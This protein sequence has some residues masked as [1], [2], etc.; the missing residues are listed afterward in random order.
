[1][2]Y[3]YTRIDITAVEEILHQWNAALASFEGNELKLKNTSLF[4]AIVSAGLDN[5]FVNSYES[6]NQNLKSALTNSSTTISNSLKNMESLDQDVQNDIEILAQENWRK[7]GNGTSITQVENK[8]LKEAPTMTELINNS[9]EQLAQYANMSMSD[10]HHVAE[11]LNNLAEMNN[12]TLD[13]ILRNESYTEKIHQTLLVSPH[14][15]DNLKSLIQIGNINISQ[16]LLADIFN[17]KNPEIIGLNDNIKNTLKTYLNT[18]ANNNNITLNQLLTDVTYDSLLKS[19]LANFNG[20]PAYLSSIDDDNVINTLLNIYD[21]NN[22]GNMNQEQTTII[23]DFLDV[24]AQSNSSDVESFLLDN[25]NIKEEMNRLGKSSV[26]INTL[27]KFSNET[28]SSILNAWKLT[29]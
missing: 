15:S 6:N 9:K 10:L 3:D 29:E 14:I 22:I 17:G 26:F 13:E 23:R 27:T 16:K 7:K 20:L 5:G 19:S 28:S 25:T 8:Y 21:G 18:I 24:S 12:T 4:S 11:E 1:M 2:K